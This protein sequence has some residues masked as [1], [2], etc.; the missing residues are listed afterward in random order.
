MESHLRYRWLGVQDTPP[1]PGTLLTLARLTL[2]P[3]PTPLT[4][5]PA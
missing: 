2:D 3:L 5:D 4:L 1:H